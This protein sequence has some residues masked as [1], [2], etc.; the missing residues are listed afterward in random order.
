MTDLG[1]TI[2]PKS[3]QLNAD[4]LIAGPITV[5]ITKVVAVPSAPEQ[6]IAI[7]FKDDNG[8]PFMPCKSM[9]R[10]LVGVWG[11]DGAG[12][13]GRSL[14]LY[15]DPDVTYGGI[16]VGGIRISHM[17]DIDGPITTALTT[18]R[19]KRQPVTVKPIQKAKAAPAP[20]P[21]P[22]Q[23]SAPEVPGGADE[24]DPFA[25]A[26]PKPDGSATPSTLT[27][28]GKDGRSFTFEPGKWRD[29]LVSVIEAK[30]F[31]FAQQTWLDNKPYVEAAYTSHPD[32]ARAVEVAWR[33]RERA[34]K[35]AAA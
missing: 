29:T 22:Q 4:D 15:R 14:T 23:N 18:S 5:E 31:D 30:P 27:L 34:A 19:T 24:A 1:N 7:H 33:K 20:P 2:A 9:R 13:V 28:I 10:L 12:Y 17:S 21:P 35:D 16:K 11:R 6:P 8:K 32:H 3:N 25:D 26:P